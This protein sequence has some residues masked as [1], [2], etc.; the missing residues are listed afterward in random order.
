MTETSNKNFV[1]L[2]WRPTTNA[3]HKHHK[4]AK[5]TVEVVTSIGPYKN[6]FADFVM[7]KNQVYYWEVKIIQGTYFKIGIIK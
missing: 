4:D 7:E 6:S 2:N 3:N 5:S 1:Y